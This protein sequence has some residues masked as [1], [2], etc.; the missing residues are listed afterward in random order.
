MD[1]LNLNY[2][3]KNI[4]YHSEGLIKRNLVNRSTDLFH[5][6]RW[7]L[8]HARNP[9]P[10]REKKERFGFRTTEPGPWSEELEEF[11]SELL[12]VVKNVKFRK[13]KRT[14]LG[15]TMKKDLD[16]IKNSPNVFVHGDKSRKI[17][18]VNK[19]KY[20]KDLEDK[21]HTMYKKV[22]R[23][24]VDATNLEAKKITERYEIADRVDQ[25]TEDSPFYTMKD[26]K[27]GFPQRV[28]LRLINPS[29]TNVGSISK[30]LLDR[31]H[32]EVMKKTKLNQ[33]SSTKDVIKWF[34]GIENKSEYKFLK[35]DIKDYYP[36]ISEEMLADT[37]MWAKEFTPIS[38]EQ[39]EAFF[40]CRKTYLFHKGEVWAKKK[41]EDFEVS[42]GGLDSCEIANI[43][44][45]RIMDRVSSLIPKKQA[46]IYRDD[47]IAVVRTTGR[48][49][50]N[51][52]KVLHRK[53]EEW[54][55]LKIT[56]EGNIQIADFLDVSMNLEDGSYRPFRKN[57]DIPVFISN[58]SN[59]APHVKKSLSNMISRRVSDLSS[60][61]EIFNQV[62]PTYNAGLKNAGFDEEIEYIERDNQAGNRKRVRKRKVIF[63][64]PPWSDQLRTNIGKKF[65]E[66]VDR[67]FPADSDIGK[68]FN[69]QNLKV[70][71]SN[72]P[73]VKRI[74]KG[75]NQKVL[76]PG[77][78]LTEKGCNC[79]VDR[80][81]ANSQSNN[82]VMEG[83]KCLTE[84]LVYRGDLE[85]TMPNPRNGQDE[86]KHCVYLGISKNSFKSRYGTHKSSFTHYDQRTSTRLAGKVW[87]LKEKNIPY[88]LK[89]SIVKQYPAYRKES[90]KCV[91]CIAERTHI[92][93]YDV[94]ND[95]QDQQTE[96]LNKRSE[97]MSKCRHRAS[98]L[99]K[100]TRGPR[101]NPRG[102]G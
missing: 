52:I 78:E 81:N 84:N 86:P 57:D 93:F 30:R 31:V 37:L 47:L 54:F 64:N 48:G 19:E 36:S 42:Q 41:N 83:S 90:K 29:K 6:M 14:K 34:E 50:D 13:P 24:V 101:P 46:I 15:D 96:L 99:L 9:D 70:S 5:R 74:I 63:F 45:L 55:K 8:W 43:C 17:Y 7:K 95:N 21:I 92:L 1:V 60:S 28:E 100:Y 62:A 25:M 73:N 77:Q 65:L 66:I 68:I 38:K 82:C 85:F 44:G 71:Y 53:F 2:S 16:R 98:H 87:K 102:D 35:L 4:G 11:E 32:A 75:H 67:C 20:T 56:C 58:E 89:F 61:E 79:R 39:E 3:E 12:D 91:L 94:E 97:L 40:H 33:A 26:H 69:R 59:H 51:M 10:N 23:N 80:A 49:C 72:L 27:P 88:R 18:E 76:N 22:D